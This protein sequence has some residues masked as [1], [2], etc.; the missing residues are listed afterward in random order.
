[1]RASP[2]E[3][4]GYGFP[5]IAIQTPA[6]RAEYVRAHQGIA[7]RSGVLRAAPAERCDQLL[8]AVS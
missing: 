7:E 6:G 5:P 2:Y 3:L 4:S 8:E 1:M